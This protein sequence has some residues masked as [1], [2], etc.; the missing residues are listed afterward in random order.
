MAADE[1]LTDQ[2]L[3]RLLA[4]NPGLAAAE[5]RLASRLGRLARHVADHEE[6]SFARFGLNRG[7]VGL[8]SAL[9]IVGP[10]HQLSP[11][12]LGRW[13]LLS[14]AGVTSRVDRLERRGLVRR[15]PDPDD[16]RGVLVELTDAGQG[17]AD[18]TVSISSDLDRALFAVLDAREQATLE[19]LL[20]KLLAT[21][22][23]R[24]LP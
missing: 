11:T 8:L 4:I 14:S 23:P 20:K 17:L 2:L 16:R 12:R 3:E 21:A 5:L 22:G 18:E 19:Q 24:A 10:P 6:E 7:E 1:D 13:L 9:R 15:L